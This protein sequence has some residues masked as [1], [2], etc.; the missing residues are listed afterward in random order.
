MLSE[1][2]IGDGCDL[3]IVERSVEEDA[4]DTMLETSV[5]EL[6]EALKFAGIA[7]NYRSRVPAD[8]VSGEEEPIADRVGNRSHNNNR[9]GELVAAPSSPPQSKRTNTPTET[10]LPDGTSQISL[11]QAPNIPLGPVHRPYKEEGL[12]NCAS[13]ASLRTLP[14][15]TTVET[16]SVPNNCTKPPTA[17]SGRWTNDEK[18]LFLYGLQKYGRGRWKLIQ[19]YCPGRCVHG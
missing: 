17:R 9:P 12:E 13:G 1:T 11:V 18:L 15:E 5:I 8:L 4:L 19:W 7:A 14:V 16:N 3:A 10:P 6:D 2:G